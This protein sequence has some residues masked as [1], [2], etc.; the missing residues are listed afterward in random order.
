[1]GQKIKSLHLGFDQAIVNT[2][3]AVLGWDGE[4]NKLEYVHSELFSSSHKWKSKSDAFILLEQGDFLKKTLKM[5]SKMA[6]IKSIAIEGVSFGSP[7]GASSRG[8]IW[9]LFVTTCLQYADVVVVPPKSL[10]M[11]V[12][13]KGTAD[14]KEIEKV[15]T[16]KYELDKLERKI[17][18]DEHDAI[19]LAEIG[20]WTW[21]IM[22]EGLKSE[23]NLEPHQLE[24]IWNKPKGLVNRVDDFYLRKI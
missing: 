21:R 18:D 3:M 22:D 5:Y 17:W 20:F 2:G 13:G 8:S 15:I 24:V 1:M 7:G 10:K 6:P 19:G 9:G 23:F 4:G 11:Y 16:P 12:T 14:K